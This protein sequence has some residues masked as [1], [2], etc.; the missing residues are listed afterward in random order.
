MNTN[1]IIQG[2]ILRKDVT[3]IDLLM[4][5]PNA[6]LAQSSLTQ[7]KPHSKEQKH[8]FSSSIVPH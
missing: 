3:Y 8:Q 4:H 6:M 1:T 2:L 7:P 5:P